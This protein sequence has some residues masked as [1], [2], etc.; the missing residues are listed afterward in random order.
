[1]RSARRTI[2][3]QLPAAPWAHHAGSRAHA[4]S[5]RAQRQ[6]GRDDG[7]YRR[8][9]RRRA[10]ALG[11]LH[12]AADRTCIDDGHRV[13]H[14]RHRRAHVLPDLRACR[15]HQM[16]AVLGRPATPYLDETRIAAALAKAASSGRSV[17]NV[18]EDDC[19]L[20]PAELAAALGAILGYRFIS[21]T[22]L[23]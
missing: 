1:A 17:L 19:G 7:A 22:E 14:R 2:D 6:H 4:S 9:L 8:V 13:D 20:G 11:G 21:S 5:G 18:L 16:N 12:D 15:E 23:A 3:R 10:G